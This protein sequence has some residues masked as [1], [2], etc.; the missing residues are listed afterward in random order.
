MSIL[1]VWVVF[2]PGLIKYPNLSSSTKEGQS[3]SNHLL[4]AIRGAEN[5]ELSLLRS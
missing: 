3:L 4:K 5:N 2:Y 1:W